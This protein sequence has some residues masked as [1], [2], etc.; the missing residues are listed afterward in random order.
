MVA[1]SLT[2]C[3]HQIRLKVRVDPK[4]PMERM[5]KTDRKGQWKKKGSGL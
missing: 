1:R 2:A 3:Y 5:G 4:S